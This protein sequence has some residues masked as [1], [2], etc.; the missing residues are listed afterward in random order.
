MSLHVIR[1]LFLKF[2]RSI[3]ICDKLGIQASECALE[4]INS[5]IPLVLE[6]ITFMEIMI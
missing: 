2:R 6:I 1:C 4:F 5:C 3:Q